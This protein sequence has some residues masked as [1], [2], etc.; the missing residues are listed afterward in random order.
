MRWGVG[1]GWEQ[2]VKQMHVVGSKRAV[3]GQPSQAFSMI[4]AALTYASEV[5][6]QVAPEGLGGW[7]QSSFVCNCRVC[8]SCNMPS[9]ARVG[10]V[11][12]VCLFRRDGGRCDR[13]IHACITLGPWQV[14]LVNIGDIIS[15]GGRPMLLLG[16]CCCSTSCTCCCSLSDAS[17]C[18]E[19]GAAA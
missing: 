5:S 3:K 11:R 14:I 9:C 18:C 8:V 19:L 16:A 15:P 17:G 1:L 10:E 2:L 13:C 12:I 7:G 4:Q 6:H